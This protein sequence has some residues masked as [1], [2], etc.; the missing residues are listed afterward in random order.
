MWI[1]TLQLDHLQPDYPFLLFIGHDL[2]IWVPTHWLSENY[3]SIQKRERQHFLVN[4]Y[5]HKT[6]F[7]AL[8]C[9][10]SAVADSKAACAVGGT[11]QQ[12]L[13]L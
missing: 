8:T 12:D 3:I 10:V 6:T 9:E 4:I 5:F 1:L 11:E 7:I 2:R 13:A